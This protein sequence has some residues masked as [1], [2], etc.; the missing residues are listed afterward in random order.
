MNTLLNELA[1]ACRLHMTTEKLLVVPSLS[2]GHQLLESLGKSGQPWLN[3]RP[4]T[5]LELAQNTAAA[6][7]K[8]QN[9]SVLS[10]GEALF[11]LEETLR[12]MEEAGELK[13]FAP[14][15]EAGLARIIY[16]TLAEMRLAGVEAARL[17]PA[18]FVHTGK[19]KE[20]ASLLL[21]YEKKLEESRLV[22]QAA[23]FRLAH[24][25]Q[26][27]CPS[28]DVILLI[29]EELEF[30]RLSYDFLS[31]FAARE[32]II[33]QSE[34]VFGLERPYGFYFSAPDGQDAQS[35]LSRLYETKN[36]ASVPGLSIFRAFGPANEIKEVLR[37]IKNAG[38]A[39]DSVLLLLAGGGYVPLSYAICERLGVPATFAGGIPLCLTRP[40]R[41]ALDL[42]RWQEEKHSSS[43][44]YRV[45]TGGDMKLPAPGLMAR[46][47]REAGVGW[48]RSRYLPRLAALTASLAQRAAAA[49]SEEQPERAGY[50]S[51]QAE[52][53]A[54]LRS[55]LVRLLGF[56]PGPDDSGL[57]DFS[58]LCTGLAEVLDLFARC[59]SRLDGE[60][61]AAAKEALLEAG[62]G[63][64]GPLPEKRALRRLREA[65]ET[66]SVGAS[67]PRPGHIHV[68][69][70]DRPVFVQRQCTFILGLDAGNFPGAA[71]QDPVLLDCERK[72]ISASLMLR[73]HVPAARNF[74][75]ARAAASRRGSITFSFPCFDPVEGRPSFPASVVLQAYRLQTGDRSA[76]YSAMLAALAAPAGY[77]PG[78]T[79]DS[80]A[81]EEWWL[82][83]VFDG[84]YRTD[85]PA[86]L[87]CYP[88]F[89]AGLLAED[90]RQSCDFTV[91]DGRVMAQLDLDPRQNSSLTLSATRIEQL[92]ACPFAYFMR[93]VLRI[94]A[95]DEPDFDP[96]AW[97]D[98]LTRGSL[99]HEIYCVYLREAYP[100]DGTQ[101]PDFDRLRRLASELI[102]RTREEVPPPSEVIFEQEKE[103]LLRGLEVFWRVEEQ[104]PG[105]PAWFEVPFG[106]GEEECKKAGLGLPGPVKLWLPGGGEVRIRGRIDRIDFDSLD[107]R[108]QVWDFKTG[109]AFGFDEREY[110]KQG[111]QVQHALYSYAAEAILRESGQD[112]QAQVESAGYIFPTEKGEG[113][114]F[115]RSQARRALALEALEKS[116]DLLSTGMFCVTDDDG[117]CTYCD[118]ITACGGK[119]TVHRSELKKLDSGLAPWKELQEYE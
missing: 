53:A 82:A 60:A 7:L 29:P 56:L 118:Y 28:S 85:L 33:L 105:A 72:K 90:A 2:A 116:L 107:H 100:H 26:T 101:A 109:S 95:P 74:R 79:R 9:L 19:G 14:L 17:D 102:D 73:S 31:S 20:V 39:F 35:S 50:Y 45:F 16:P 87:S 78:N 70:T 46:L 11:L 3:M 93:Y 71:L 36:T 81:E 5:P 69:G 1:A 96:A 37:R 63:C 111:R 4:V 114:R 106:F 23:V 68:C 64:P 110:L 13:Y 91:Y 113:Q 119:R 108:Y 48:G 40:G 67:A 117:L 104:S 59:G 18:D 61:L 92:A 66:V 86:V 34:P 22:D 47:L 43:L 21:R 83:T 98:P 51:K 62:R 54:D 115:A 32:K 30:S 8:R 88:G 57:T 41:L 84:Y 75:L 15:Q 42:V 24:A 44:L 52:Y 80:L 103:E 89:A 55:I 99:L 58:L 112:P 6:E 97:L 49:L 25:L 38:T 76:D 77:F 12:E 94:E 10:A 27:G 65:L